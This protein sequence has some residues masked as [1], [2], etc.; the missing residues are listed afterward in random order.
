MHEQGKILLGNMAL[1]WAKVGRQPKQKDFR[2]PESSFSAD[3]YVRRYGSWRKALEVFVAAANAGDTP[4][5]VSNDLNPP[6]APSPDKK[7]RHTPREPGWRLR[8][9]VMRRDRFSCRA[10]GRTPAIDPGVLLDVDHV[11]AWSK[12]GE[13]VIENLQTLCQK[14]NVGKSDLPMN[15]ED[16]C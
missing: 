16:K 5:A 10:C 9:L 12:D 2:P 8:F 11:E 7:L 13:T 14:C 1:V 4:N 15:E 6:P 3:A